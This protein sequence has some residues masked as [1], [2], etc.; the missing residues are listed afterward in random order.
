MVI[1]RSAMRTEHRDR[2][3]GG[4]GTVSVTSFVAPG[5]LPHGRL[6]AEL[7]IPVG[8]SIGEHEHGAETEY[9]VILS[10]RGVVADGGVQTEVSAG[11]VV[12]TG[13]GASHSIRNSSAEPLRF[14]ALIITH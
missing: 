10:G 2:M 14:V 5:D 1:R 9:Y 3:R 7:E 11:D 8:G 13:G 6:L 4:E 12:V